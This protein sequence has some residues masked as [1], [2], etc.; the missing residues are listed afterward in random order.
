MAR[1]RGQVNRTLLGL[2]V[3]EGAVPLAQG[4]RLFQGDAE[5]GQVT[6]STFSPRLQKVIALAYVRRGHQQPGTELVIESASAGRKAIVA[7]LPLIRG[8]VNR[9]Q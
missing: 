5:V 8:A 6:S 2:T 9:S 7:E 3:S 4:T 1:D